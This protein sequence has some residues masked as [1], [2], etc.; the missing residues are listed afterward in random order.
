MNNKFVEQQL[1]VDSFIC[2]QFAISKFHTIIEHMYQI[3]IRVGFADAIG[4]V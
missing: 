4:W 3:W 1:I 2:D